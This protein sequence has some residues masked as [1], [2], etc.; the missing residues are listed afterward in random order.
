MI[1]FL[2]DNFL[3]LSLSYMF[4]YYFKKNESFVSILNCFERGTK[5]TLN[6]ILL[7]LKRILIEALCAKD[8]PSFKRESKPESV[9]EDFISSLTI[10]FLRILISY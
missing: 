9:E 3:S 8:E 5:E 6:Y 4:N 10:A 2:S 7:N 1:D